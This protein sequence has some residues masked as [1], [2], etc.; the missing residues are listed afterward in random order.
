MSDAPLE[1]KIAIPDIEQVQRQMLTMKEKAPIVMQRAINKTIQHVSS[2]VGKEAK[3]QYIAKQS[4]IKKTLKIRKAKKSD[5]TGIVESVSNKKTRLYGFK[6]TPKDINTT[7]PIDVYSA[8]I[9]KRVSEKELVGNSK[10]SKAFVARM[11]SGHIGIFERTAGL[12]RKKK[13]DGRTLENDQPIAELYALSIP[14]MI[15]S[16]E[17]AFEIRQKGTDFLRKQID[18][19]IKR[20]MGVKAK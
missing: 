12:K 3:K 6:V 9:R 8:R 7:N 19:E 13:R 18:I 15:K 16:R 17:V 10:R 1:L 20:V 11:S 14:S 2:L 5:L 4:E